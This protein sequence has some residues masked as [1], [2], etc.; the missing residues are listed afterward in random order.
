MLK[1]TSFEVKMS[2][3]RCYIPSTPFLFGIGGASEIQQITPRLTVLVALEKYIPYRNIA[4]HEIVID[5]EF[6]EA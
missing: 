4:V 6:L 1:K 3:H 5:I 2:T